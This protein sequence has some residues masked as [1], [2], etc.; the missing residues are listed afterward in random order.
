MQRSR[1]VFSARGKKTFTIREMDS[2]MARYHMQHLD[3]EMFF[4]GDRFALCTMK[5]R[6]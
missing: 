1:V 6:S 3:Q 4:D 2:M 5:K